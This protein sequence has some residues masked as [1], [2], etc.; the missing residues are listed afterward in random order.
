MTKT[1]RSTGQLC[2]TNAYFQAWLIDYKALLL[3]VAKKFASGA[4]SRLLDVRW[5]FRTLCVNKA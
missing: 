2:Q 1:K 4:R 5:K 3:H